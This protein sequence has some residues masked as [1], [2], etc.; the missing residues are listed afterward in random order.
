[1]QQ[2]RPY[3][4]VVVVGEH[5]QTFQPGPGTYEEGRA[6]GIIMRSIIIIYKTGSRDFLWMQKNKL[7]YIINSM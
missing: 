3:G 5:W 1:M 2:D 6:L 4:I 7:L